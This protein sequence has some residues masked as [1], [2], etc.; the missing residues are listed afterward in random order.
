[1]RTVDI[2]TEKPYQVRIGRGLLKELG[3]QL[4]LVHRPCRAVVVTDSTVGPLYLDETLASLEGAGF[5]AESYVMPAGEEHKSAETFL[6]IQRF[7]I[8]TELTRSDLLV[9]LGGGVVGDMTGFCAATYQR[10]IPFVQVPTTLLCAVDASVGGKTAIDLPEGKNMVGAFHQPILVLCDTETFD[11][12]PDLRWQ[13][14]AAEMLKHGV[15]ADGEMFE[16]LAAG[17]W[18]EQAE[19][20]VQK[21]V[22]IKRSFVVGDEKDKGKRQLLNF[23]HTVGHAVEWLSEFSLS[24]GQAVAIGMVAE[25]RA[26]RKMGLTKLDEE[27]ILREVKANGLPVSYPAAA[28]DVAAAILRDKKRT[29]GGVAV[30]VPLRLGET[31]LHTL[32]LGQVREYVEMG[33]MP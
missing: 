24:H 6:D 21:N 1:M 5:S 12:L 8:R 23:G 2:P 15:L 14:G 26:A 11:T 18:R 27:I 7:L 4:A 10:G 20:L 13:D 19:E 16:L 30:C 3:E 25:T 28:Q 29:D 32:P 9:A 17:S 33:L 31:R 22:E